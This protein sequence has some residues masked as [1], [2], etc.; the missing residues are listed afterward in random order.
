MTN[1]AEARDMAFDPDVKGRIGKDRRCPLGSNQLGMRSTTSSV[2]AVDLM[3]SDEP[4]IPNAG[5]RRS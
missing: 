3:L 4:K 5:D 1:L 2:A